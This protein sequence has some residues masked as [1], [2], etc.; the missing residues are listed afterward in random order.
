MTTSK[1]DNLADIVFV[2]ADADEV[3]SYVIGRYEAITGRTLAKGDPVRLFL[4]TIA[5]LIVLLLN[6]IN[7]TGKQNLLRYATGDNLDHLGALVGVERIPAKAAVTTMRIKLSAKLQTATIIPAGTRF[8]AGDNL[9]FA[10]DDPLVI[11]AGTISA[12][13]SATCLTKGE[14]GNGYVAGQLK[15]LVDPVP[16]VDSV[17]NITTSEGGVEVQSDDSYREDIR[18]APENFSTAGPKGAYIYHAKRASTKIADVTV[19]SPEAG[20]VEVRPLLAGGELPGDEML[21]QVKTTLDDKKVRPLTDNI[22]VL[23]PEKVTYNLSLTY[24]IA[25]DNKAQAT[26]IQ[27]A[28]NAAVDDYV[29][30]QKSKLGRDINPSELIA[31]VMAAGAKRVAVTAPVF[32]AITDTQV[33]VC[34][35]K[36]VTLG[37]IEDA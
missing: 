19:W 8:T 7:E 9:F 1:L 36:T 15:T 20:K 22:S 31:R 34:G 3:E 35:T 4:L 26:A 23:A 27:N 6:K 5:A 2:D 14:L 33:A 28:V 37:G 13:G 21:Q 25:S 30:W 11:D 10:L 12:D 24:Y 29:L 32:T 17:A 16:Y 18:L